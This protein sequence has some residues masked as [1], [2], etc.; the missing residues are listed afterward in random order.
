MINSIVQI[1]FVFT[2]FFSVFLGGPISIIYR[3]RG[4]KSP[5]MIVEQSVLLFIFLIKKIFFSFWLCWVF[6][7]VRGLSLVV[8]ASLVAEHRLQA[9][10]LQQ[11]QHTGS[12]VAAHRPQ[13]AQ[14]SVVVA[15]GLNSCGSQALEHRLGS[16]GTQAQ[17]LRSMW[18]LPGSGIEPVSPALAGGFLTTAPPGKS[19]ILL[20]IFNF[21]FIQTFI[22]FCFPC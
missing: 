16:C 13:S 19:H 11:L 17:L 21:C 7:A 4:I 3:E 10:G 5:N 22:I 20:L 1:F 6:V 12:V 8:V 9:H 18:D 2:D 15:R 14:V